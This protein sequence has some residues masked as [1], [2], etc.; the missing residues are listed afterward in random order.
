MKLSVE[1]TRGRKK[2]KKIGGREKQGG[3]QYLP[4]ATHVQTEWKPHIQN[5]YCKQSPETGWARVGG[6]GG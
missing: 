6:G 3:R 5:A 1:Q 2:K 4:V